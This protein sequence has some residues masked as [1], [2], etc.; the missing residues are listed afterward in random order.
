MP[1][2]L[3]NVV[4]DAGRTRGARPG[5]AVVAASLICCGAIGLACG[6]RRDEPAA[7]GTPMLADEDV[8]AG[9][10]HA[11]TV[12]ALHFVPQRAAPGE[13]VQAV[14][15]GADEDGDPV[16]L[17]YSWMVDGRRLLDEGSRITVPESAG[18]G[19]IE[20]TVIAT[21]GEAESAPRI[22]RFRAGNRP[23]RIA[24]LDIETVQLPGRRG[25]EPHWHVMADVIDPDRNE[26][27]VE[28]EWIVNDEVVEKGVD[29]F[30]KSRVGR[31]DEVRVRGTPF[32][33]QAHGPSLESAAIVIGNAPPEIV[34]AP[35]GLD[36]TGTFRYTPEVRDPDRDTQFTFAL[37]TGPEAM[38]IDAGTGELVWTPQPSD[39][40][41][42]P[43]EIQVSDASGDRSRQRFSVTVQVGGARPPGPAARR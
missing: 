22:G 42:H 19:T 28:Y 1:S 6:S 21:D 39:V 13:R 31:G 17:R 23:P 25:E 12:T 37:L 33:G 2:S 16:T 10:N 41:T 20:V 4:S 30:A 32:D 9:G 36:A 40:G 26:T 18:N 7:S 5:L 24:G 8:L 34:S 14:A 3:A 15:V 43:V 27:S 35:P 29:S 38:Q 11:P